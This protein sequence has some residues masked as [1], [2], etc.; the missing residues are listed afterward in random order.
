MDKRLEALN[1]MT[2]ND[3]VNGL[4]PVEGQTVYSFD[5]ELFDCDQPDFEEGEVYYSGKVK[6]VDMEKII[7]KN[8]IYKLMEEIKDELFYLV[9]EEVDLDECVKADVN[10]LRKLIVDYY[11]QKGMITCFQVE[12]VQE[13]AM[14]ESKDV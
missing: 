8:L 5:G 1:E 2:E 11:N 12:Y 6:N 4:Y 14:E 13:H 10:D 7:S 9:P 3:Q